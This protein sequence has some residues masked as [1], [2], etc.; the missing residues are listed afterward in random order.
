MD[1]FAVQKELSNITTE[2]TNEEFEELRG[3]S[4]AE[5]GVCD[6][7]CVSLGIFLGISVIALFLLF[8]LQV[9][10]IVITIR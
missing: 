1:N 10:N 5:A 2:F 9:P 3:M 7:G 8:F 4:T 6:T